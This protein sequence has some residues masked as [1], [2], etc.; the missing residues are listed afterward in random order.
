MKK[1]L[2]GA[3]I[4]SSMAATMATA[5]DVTVKEGAP[6]RYTVVKGDTLWDIS[7]RFLKDPWR[8]PEIWQANPQIQ[9]PH[10]IYPGDNILLCMVNGQQVL[11][12]DA[13]GGCAEVAQR[14]LEGKKPSTDTLDGGDTVKLRPQVRVEPLGVAVPALP[15][16]E[17]QRYM[18]DSRVVSREE[19]NK[20]PYVLAGNEN[21]IIA[22]AGDTVFARGNIAEDNTTYGIYRPGARYDDPDTGEVLGYEAEDVGT[23]KVL[24]RENDVA[25][26]EITRMAQ[27]VRIE[28]RLLPSEQ[29]RVTAMF[30]PKSPD[31][32]KPGKVIRIMGGV[33]NAAKYGVIVLNRGE[34][35]GVQQ[36]H[37]F[38]LYRK[39]QSVRDRVSNEVVKL[40][41]E[42]EGLAMVFRTFAKVSYALILKSERPVKVGDDARPPRSGD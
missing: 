35:D 24:S 30:Y 39:A 20:A 25:T 18:T 33:D 12:V 37:V 16:K 11:A 15:L 10:L 6:D 7:N 23:G 17:I 40:P 9:N 8:W 28:D 22:G 14:V 41:A 32:V 5:E 21:R 38:A 29:R 27:D 34:R 36:G 1:L 2:L 4:A 19:L 13:G 26:I 31:A 42:K 3:L